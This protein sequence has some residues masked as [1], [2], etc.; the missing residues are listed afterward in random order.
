[1][2]PLFPFYLKGNQIS[3][4]FVM[5][6]TMFLTLLVVIAPMV[7]YQEQPNNVGDA[8]STSTEKIVRI[9]GTEQN[10]LNPNTIYVRT[11]D[12]ITFVNIDGTNR[13]T[14]HTIVSVK[15]GTTEPDGTF[16]SGLIKT[17]EFFQFTFTEPGIYEYFDSLYPSIRGTIHVV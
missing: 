3:L 1:M 9:M 4:T 15:I 10:S 17:G 12:T 13:G 5:K 14:T 8:Q 7:S 6:M 16:D 2:Y 11:H